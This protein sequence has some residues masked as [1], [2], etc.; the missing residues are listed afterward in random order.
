MQ[1]TDLVF[2]ALAAIAVCAAVG[3][4]TAKNPV[5]SVLLLVLTFFACAGTWII[6][7]AEFLGIALVLVYVGAVMVLFLFVVM[8]LDLNIERM[9][10]GFVKNL[11]FGILVAVGM[12]T[13][14]L[15]VVGAKTFGPSK[16]AAVAATDIPNAKALGYAL[17][18]DYVYPVEIAAVIL[19]VAIVAA[20]SLTLRHR[21]ETKYQ[22]PAQQVRVRREDRV[23]LVKVA[24]EKRD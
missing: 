13:V 3:V 10:Q 20:I 4:I 18:T 5:H 14:M 8:M 12:V 21:P 22:N 24:A 9:R 7:Q 11:P 6:A 16:S 17:F 19:L 2:Y 1:L 15:L 23:R